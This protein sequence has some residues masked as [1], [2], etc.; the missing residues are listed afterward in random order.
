MKKQLQFLIIFL[1]ATIG[2]I[3]QNGCGEI[4]MDEGGT[5]N[6]P[7]DSNYT[8]TLCPENPGDAVTVTFVEFDIEPNKDGLYIF[9]GNSTSGAQIATINPA[10][11]VPAG[12]PGAFWGS[13]PIGS[14][15]SSSP[16]G[17][18]TF[19][20][21]SDGTGNR[22]G[23]VANVSCEYL[24][25]LEINTTVYTTEQLVNQVLIDNPCLE[26]SNVTSITG[27]NFGS[28]NG[29]GYFQNSNPNFPLSSGIVLSTGNVANIPGP[30]DSSVTDGTTLWLG[31]DDLNQTVYQAGGGPHESV[32]ATIL[33]FDFMAS[34]EFMSFNFLFASEEY[35]TYQ[36]NFS[37]AF[38]FLLTDY[39]TGIT[40]NLAVVPGTQSPVSVSTIRDEAYNPQCT[41]VNPEFFDAFYVELQ[42]NAAV[43]FNGVTKA[44][45]ASS[46]LIPNHPYHIK[47]VIADRLD[48]L[49]DSAVF[50]E[51]GSFTSGP[52][53]CTDKLSLVAF[54]DENADGIR[55]D[56]E[57]AFTHGSFK[58]VK[59]GENEPTFVNPMTGTYN[60]FDTDPSNTYAL[61]YEIESEFAP[62]YTTSAAYTNLTIPVGSGSQTVYFPVTLSQPF[63]DVAVMIVPIG[64]P[65][66]DMTYVNKIVYTNIGVAAASGTLTF[67]KDA[68][69]QIAEVSQPGIV[70]NT[71]GFSYA[72]T[73]LQPN[74]TRSVYVTLSVPAPPAVDLDDLLTTRAEISAPSAD[75]NLDNND[76]V[77]TQIV[78]NSMDPNM[79]VEAHGEMID[80]NSFTSNEY[81]YYTIYFQNMGT[82][83]AI[84]VAV[85]DMLDSRLDHSSVV[86]LNASHNVVVHRK[87]NKLLWDFDYIMLPGQFENE[88]LSKGYVFFKV[89]VR[90][91]FEAGDIIPN[92]A[93]IIFDSNA[94]I[95]TNTFNTT[96]FDSLGTP[97]FTGFDLVLYPNPARGEFRVDMTRTNEK[98]A[99]IAVYDVIG[100]M[101]LKTDAA[102]QDHAKVTI[103]GFA[104]GIYLVEILTETNVR[105]VRKLVVE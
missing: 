77:N 62:Y 59:N 50:I 88:Q 98:L 103:S 6:Y 20:F 10:S 5:E 90:P 7:P 100:K 65:R 4:F 3:A 39:E 64:A 55:D 8:I 13:I 63:N 73:N 16:D 24:S 87:N 61:G 89:K 58:V 101:M 80:I 85:E 91:G 76:F 105:L 32:N 44:M 49:Y 94:T 70:Q 28:V 38:A 18:L 23:W 30:N 97:E 104:K 68:L 72:F 34:N 74:E 46:A 79:I 43:N 99:S 82:A 92:T 1:F 22:S 26:V 2:T 53:Q 60:L 27:T 83:S 51:A 37:D 42:N 33:E 19:L 29:I 54:I 67:E 25:P 81:L 47:L 31:D 9:N 78:V 71:N 41:S 35:G 57:S 96:F 52:P 36:C 102:G 15:T 66:P 21:S 56:S 75:V 84:R 69:T 40:T 17:C 14:F 93:E 11:S 95:V 45:T 86:M 12:L 48:P